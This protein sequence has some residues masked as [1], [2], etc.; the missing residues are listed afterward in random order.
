LSIALCSMGYFLAWLYYDELVIVFSNWK[1]IPV[2]WIVELS[3]TLLCFRIFE[4][5]LPFRV[6]IDYCVFFTVLDSVGFRP[7]CSLAVNIVGNP[8]L[9]YW[10]GL[11]QFLRVNL[12]RLARLFT[13]FTVLEEKSSSS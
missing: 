11:W 4:V 7:F 2:Y 3:E 1:G 10:C 5:D 12:K 6:E 13:V 8:C 9:R